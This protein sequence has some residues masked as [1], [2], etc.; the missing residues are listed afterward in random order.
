M[1]KAIKI[2]IYVY[3]R[4]RRQITSCSVREWNMGCDC[5]WYEKTGY[6]GE[7]NINSGRAKN[8]VN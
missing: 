6:M 7:E 5:D 3:T 8:T 4:I 2:Q 1:S